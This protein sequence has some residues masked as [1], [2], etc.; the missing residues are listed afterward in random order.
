MQWSVGANNDNNLWQGWNTVGT[1][2]RTI[3]HTY[4][5]VLESN[6]TFTVYFDGEAKAV[7]I[8][9]GGASGWANGIAKGGL[10]AQARDSG[11]ILNTRFVIPS[12][13][14]GISR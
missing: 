8:N 1:T 2:D 5:I 12:K 6:F 4:K 14:G 7:G 3:F 11:Q 10:Y 9:A 13:K